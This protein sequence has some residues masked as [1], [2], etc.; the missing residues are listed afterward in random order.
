MPKAF[1]FA[2]SF[3]KLAYIAS[4]WLSKVDGAVLPA[5]Q[6]RIVHRQPICQISK[7]VRLLPSWFLKALVQLQDICNT[8][9]A[10]DL[11]SPVLKGFQQI[12]K[13]LVLNG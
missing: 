6:K 5:F 3:S 8:I 12:Q 11:N 1:E 9:G 13:L 2:E 4:G 10:K 7:L